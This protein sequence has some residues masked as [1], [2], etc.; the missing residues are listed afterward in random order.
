MSARQRASGK[1]P[2]TCRSCSTRISFPVFPEQEGEVDVVGRVGGIWVVRPLEVSQAAPVVSVVTAVTGSWYEQ[3]PGRVGDEQG[4]TAGAQ[5]HGHGL[6][7]RAKV[8]LCRDVRDR[9]VHEHGIEG[10]LEPQ[11]PHVALEVLALGVQRPA[12]REHLRGEIR[13]RARRS[14]SSD[15]TRCFRLPSRARAAF[16]PRLRPW[17]RS[18]ERRSPLPRRSRTDASAGGTRGRAL[19]RSG[20]QTSV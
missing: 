8:V 15:A 7:G 17:R 10:A 14:G 5:M 1:T 3:L 13:E 19:R 2:H 6:D 11:R 20:E 16:A 4:R 9:V 18:R 12:Q